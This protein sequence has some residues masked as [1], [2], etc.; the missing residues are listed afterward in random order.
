MTFWNI[1]GIELKKEKTIPEN[2]CNLCAA[3]LLFLHFKLLFHHSG[4]SFGFVLFYLPYS[5]LS[6]S[7]DGSKYDILVMALHA[8]A[9]GHKFAIVLLWQ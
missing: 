7:F 8:Y 2:N 1:A 4:S 9:S 6:L 3:T 5:I